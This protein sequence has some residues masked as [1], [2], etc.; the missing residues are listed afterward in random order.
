[1]VEEDTPAETNQSCLNQKRE[2]RV[3][4]REV[5]VRRLPERNAVT[6]IQN[7]TRV[8]KHREVRALPQDYGS[9]GQKETARR[10]EVAQVPAAPS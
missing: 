8:P 4:Q 10:D 2:R 6:G 7:V 1:M 5:A 9:A 3:R